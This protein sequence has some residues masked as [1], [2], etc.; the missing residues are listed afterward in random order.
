MNVSV[1][2]NSQLLMSVVPI[3][4]LA[5]TARKTMMQPISQAFFESGVRPFEMA[6]VKVIYDVDL[7]LEVFFV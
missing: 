6:R 7:K 2:S 3:S 5:Q 1:F 4:E